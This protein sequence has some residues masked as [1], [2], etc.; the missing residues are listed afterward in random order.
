MFC[1]EDRVWWDRNFE[2]LGAPFWYAART[3]ERVQKNARTPQA[4]SEHTDPQVALRLFHVC[5]G[6]GKL[7]FSSRVVSHDAHVSELLGFD[8]VDRRV[9]AKI[10]GPN[11]SAKELGKAQRSLQIASLGL[12][13]TPSHASGAY[14]ASRAPT[15]EK[16]CE[17]DAN[18]VWDAD[19]PDANIRQ[20][21]SR[22]D[23]YIGADRSRYTNAPSRRSCP[24]D[25]TRL[26]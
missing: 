12:R 15:A 3:L 10:T 7:G 6:F 4:S 2:F 22:L 5:S 9:F 17:F 14:Q 24:N 25:W 18:F 26:D 23:A 11:P 13:S 8:K 1:F 19:D 16:C 20:T 21:L